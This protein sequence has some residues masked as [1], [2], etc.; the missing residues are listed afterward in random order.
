ML[1]NKTDIVWEGLMLRV[2]NGF[3]GMTHPEQYMIVWLVLFS[4]LIL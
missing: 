4:L 3:E 2:I 1:K